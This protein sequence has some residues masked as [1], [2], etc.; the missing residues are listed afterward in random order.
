MTEKLY[1]HVDFGDGTT[2]LAGQLIVDDKL[3]R[4]KYAKAYIAHPRAFALDPINLPLNTDI[5]AKHRTR[6]T[7]AMFGV[8]ID[9]G[10][11]EWGR[12]CL[13]KT[14]RPP[15]VTQVEFLLAA[16]GE[17]VG[18]LVFTANLEDPVK[19]P[20]ERPFE[21]LVHLQHIAGDI[22]SGKEVD[23]SLE[24]YFFHGSG[25]GGARPKSLI[26]NDGREWIAKFN[27]PSDLVDMCRVELASMRMARAAGIEVPDVDLT[28]T[29]RGPVLLVER[30]DQSPNERHHLVS[31][32]SLINKFDITEIDEST[33][34]YPGITQLGK[35]IGHL[36]SDL[37]AV[38]FRRMLFNVAIGNTDDHL[39]NH[40][41]MK[42][43]PD[44]DYSLS[45]AYDIVPQIS[46]QGSHAIAIGPFGSSPSVD[47]IQAAA[48]RMGVA[49]EL[50]HEIADAV[51]E[52]TVPWRDHMI[53]AGVG[54]S[55]L[56]LLERCFGL[57]DVVERWHNKAPRTTGV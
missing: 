46:L 14:R 55:E 38:V 26:E 10:P 22:E 12:R 5:H 4:F 34:S 31:V 40:A 25:L 27:R 30:F 33:M 45:P 48:R 49:D 15:P 32:A 57:R 36:T 53:D 43:A 13:T 54:E 52:V 20:P 18:A 17:G 41:F 44:S 23:R 37:G 3:G 47:N 50:A 42:R 39:R 16:S 11:D 24:P 19:P 8:L 56:S 29:D 1:V 2:L 9:A 6:D 28:E 7:P 51:L 35:R 21:N